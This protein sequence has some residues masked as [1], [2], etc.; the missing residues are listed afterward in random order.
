MGSDRD[1]DA[2]EGARKVI[3][4]ALWNSGIDWNGHTREGV[5]SLAPRILAALAEAG[6]RVARLVKVEREPFILE[7]DEEMRARITD[8]GRKALAGGEG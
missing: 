6:F 3:V 1:K 7:T 2:A 4:T 5:E 8:A